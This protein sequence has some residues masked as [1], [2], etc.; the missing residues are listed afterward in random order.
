MKP[1]V[2]PEPLKTQTNSEQSADA[3]DE[4]GWYLYGITSRDVALQLAAKPAT[5][6][7]AS[8]LVVEQGRLAGVTRLVSRDAF[9]SEALQARAQDLGWLEDAVRDHNGVVERIHQRGA[10]LPVK[11][12]SVY[13]T[14][15]ALQADLAKMHDTLCAQ[16][17]WLRAC[18]EWGIHLY[19]DHPAMQR[20]AGEH[21]TLRQMQAEMAVASPG[22]A[23]LFKRKLVD[24]MACVI[25]QALGE[26]AQT[27][28]RRIA[29]YAIAGQIS[30]RSPKPADKG[31]ERE[32]L[33]ATF[34]VQRVKIDG[35]LGE[36]QRLVQE[37]EGIRCEYSGP[38]PPYSFASIGKEEH[39]E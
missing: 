32:V 34:L 6:R 33:H 2:N 11:F 21:P 18:D 23:Y 5:D 37:Q 13:P 22:R 38:W 16:L 15:E 3:G 17:E 39:R 20:L 30:P 24:A 7:H 27:S 19:A 26:L 31:D 14:S 36:I 4:L 10:V 29:A 35:F 1:L 28:Y 8:L 25:D 9:T 12:G